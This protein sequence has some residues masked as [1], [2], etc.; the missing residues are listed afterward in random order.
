MTAIDTRP[1]DLSTPAETD[2]SDANCWQRRQQSYWDAISERYDQLYLGRWSNLEN[3]WVQRQL[4][5]IGKFP[6]PTVL[7][8]GCGTGLGLRIIHDLNKYAQYIGVDVSQQMVDGLAKAPGVTKVHVGSMDNLDFLNPG[9]VDV[10]FSLFASLSYA[11]DTEDVF[12]EIARVLVPGGYAYLSILSADALSRLRSGLRNRLYRTR[13][14]H[15][16]GIA[17]PVRRHSVAS[18]R[19]LSH[20]AGLTMVWA[21][22]MNVF[23]GF[24]EVP[25]LW[26]VGRVAAWLLPDRAHTIEVLL[27]KEP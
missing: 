18:I 14:D 5:F 2:D 12:R 6:A 19:A 9:Q 27:R 20:A 25:G 22:G 17:A 1:G 23:S 21:T 15:Q 4:S 24:V 26:W 8:L 13:G 16:S 7:D 3:R 10:V 11:Y